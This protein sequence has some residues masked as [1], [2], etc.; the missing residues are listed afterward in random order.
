MVDVA[1]VDISFTTVRAVVLGDSSIAVGQ[2]LNLRRIVEVAVVAFWAHVAN[3]TVAKF[4]QLPVLIAELVLLSLR[5]SVVV[6]GLS[7]GFLSSRTRGLVAASVVE[8]VEKQRE[9]Q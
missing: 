6:D 7:S 8:H 9:K 4:G 2:D 3:T 1:H 5:V